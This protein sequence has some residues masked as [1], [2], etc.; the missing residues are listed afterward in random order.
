MS[1]KELFI[2]I[3]GQGNQII[4]NGPVEKLINVHKIN[5]Q[6]ESELLKNINISLSDKKMSC[7]SSIKAIL[8]TK[9]L[10]DLQSQIEKN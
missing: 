8:K 1:T 6:R 4:N 7:Q 5:K 3:V 2:I 9:Q 10:H